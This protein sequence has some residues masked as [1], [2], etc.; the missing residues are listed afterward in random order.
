VAVG[1]RE[2]SLMPPATLIPRN[3]ASRNNA[4]RSRLLVVSQFK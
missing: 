4:C 1:P 3:H 2:R